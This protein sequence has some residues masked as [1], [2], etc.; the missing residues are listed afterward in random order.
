MKVKK[1]L[2][3]L[4]LVAMNVFAEVPVEI[5][6]TWNLNKDATSKKL[7]SIEGWSE[8][9]EAMLEKVLERMSNMTY[10][11]KEQSIEV[12]VKGRVMVTFEAQ[13]V[14]SEGENILVEGL[15]KRG[16][17]KMKVTLTFIPQGEGLYII[18]SSK[19]NDMD[20]YVWQKS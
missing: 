9:D 6:G 3:L 18:K 12:S 20:H 7:Q 16:D 8:K 1:L 15:A 19:T 2:L 13:E 11:V 5:V 10:I 4:S 17:K 14:S